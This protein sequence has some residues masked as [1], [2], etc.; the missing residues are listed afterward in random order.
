[1]KITV[2]ATGFQ[3]DNLPKIARPAATAVI[4]ETTP[5]PP[6]P[7]APEFSSFPFVKEPEPEPVMEAVAEPEPLPEPAPQMPAEE[8]ALSM[9]DLDVPAYLRRNR[10]LY[11]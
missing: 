6:P 10:R 11:Q 2:I 5:E 9:N 4:V 3:R 8:P 1:M 7:V